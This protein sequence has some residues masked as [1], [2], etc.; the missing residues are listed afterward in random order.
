MDHQKAF[1]LLNRG[2]YWD[3]FPVQLFSVLTA[4]CCCTFI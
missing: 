4:Y 3:V 2:E 1:Y